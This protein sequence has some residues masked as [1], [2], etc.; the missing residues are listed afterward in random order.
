MKGIGPNKLGA[1]KAPV[2]QPPVKQTTKAKA[3]ESKEIPTRND[4]IVSAYHHNK[5]FHKDKYY[6]PD[7]NTRAKEVKNKF[8]ELDQYMQNRENR[9]KI[10][11]DYE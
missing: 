4:S 9:K 6:N 10:G 5:L 2:K 11:Q 8:P 7:K 3:F 1:P